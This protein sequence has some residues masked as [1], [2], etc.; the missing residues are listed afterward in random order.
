MRNKEI[1]L[2]AL[3][4]AIYGEATFSANGYSVSRLVSDSRKV[5]R[6]DLF[7]ALV[8][9][10]VDAHSHVP[11]AL[12]RGAVAV[13][14][15]RVLDPSAPVICVPDTRIALAQAAAEFYGMPHLKLELIGITGTNGKTTTTYMIKAIAKAAGK[16]F[17]TIGTLG[18][19]INDKRHPLDFTTPGP[20]QLFG[21]LAEMVEHGLDGVAME[22]SSHGIEQQRCRGLIFSAIGFTNLTQD[23]LDYHHDMESY[24]AVKSR[25]FEEAESPSTSVIGVDD[26]YGARLV[27]KTASERVITYAINSPADLVASDIEFAKDHTKFTLRADNDIAAI[28]L[29]VPGEFNVYNA[30][31]AIGIGISMGLPLDA[32]AAGLESFKGI[33][34]RLELVHGSGDFAVYVDYSHTPDS[35]RH[36]IQ[37]CR[38]IAEGRVITVFGA[39]GDRDRDKRPKMGDVAGSLSDIIVI[40]NDNPRTEDPARIIDQIVSG[41]PA[42][43]T[44][45]RI[46]D[47]REAIRH[48]LSLAEAGDVVLIAGKGHEDYQIIGKK[49]NHFD[50]REV[51]QEWFDE[52]S[53]KRFES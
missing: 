39:G 4:E 22:V 5:R 37:A 50:D 19:T 49:K 28:R 2:S 25:L 17:G 13:V 29:G 14:V 40:T 10:T 7:F 6:G 33:P 31:C 32:V 11:E 47:R 41:V 9:E 38:Q 30:L 3:I 18:Y 52:F 8:G 48:A 51:A 53:G 24:F 23:H 1:Q 34:G 42:G 20:V 36:A 27:E 12:E 43:A 44:M 46:E 45:F 21:T 35:L 15:E 26:E 16:S